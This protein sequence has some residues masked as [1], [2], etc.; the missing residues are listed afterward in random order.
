M[1]WVTPA[2]V[3]VWNTY[4]SLKIRKWRWTSMNE[5]TWISP[6]LETMQI[7]ENTVFGRSP[8]PDDI[9][10]YD[11][12]IQYFFKAAGRREAFEHPHPEKE[13]YPDER[14]NVDFSQ[15]RNGANQWGY[16]KW[17]YTDNPWW[18]FSGQLIIL[19]LRGGKQAGISGAGDSLVF[20]YASP[21]ASTLGG[22]AL[23]ARH[24]WLRV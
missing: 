19:F 8:G 23:M 2:T 5:K 12:W 1:E 11:S 24:A 3:I 21:P 17:Y 20:L 4:L 6:V 16:W 15:S 13:V 10:A 9:V 18:H 7:N 22:I 14:K